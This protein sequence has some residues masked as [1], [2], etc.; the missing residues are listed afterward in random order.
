MRER[1]LPPGAPAEEETWYGRHL[2]ELTDTVRY[3]ADGL[4]ASYPWL[5]YDVNDRYPQVRELW[6]LQEDSNVVAGFA[7]EGERAW[8]TTASGCVRC[9]SVVDGKRLW[10]RQFGGKIFSTP[11]V[12]DGLLVFGCTDGCIYALDAGSGR[13][14]W[15]VRAGKSVLASPVVFDGKVFIGASDGVF[16]ALALESGRE[17]WRFDG[18]EGFVECRAFVDAEQVVFGS[19]S[20]RLYSLDTGS[21]ALQWTWR[22]ER[23]SRMYSPAAT[24]PV[25]ACGRIFIAVPDRKVYALDARTGEELFRAD[26]GREAIGLSSDGSTVLV[27]TM[28]NRSYAFRADVRC[29]RELLPEELAWSVPNGMGYE[30]GPSALVEIDGMVLTPSDKGNLFAFSLQDGSLMWVRKISVALVNPLEAWEEPDGVCILASAM[31][32][33]VTL[34]KVFK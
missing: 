10:S 2:C 14:K 13:V 3:D 25:K 23:P 15:T 24:W 29:G 28:H 11:A 26:G 12:G 22:C 8:F 18:V 5:R 19:W 9:I 30:I 33:I 1:R 16:R 17:V 34:L 7:R 31:D 27:K 20:G 21:G 32:G 4:P 6:R